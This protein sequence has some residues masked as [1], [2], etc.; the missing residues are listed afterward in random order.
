MY[1]DSSDWDSGFKKGFEI[2]QKIGFWEAKVQAISAELTDISTTLSEN[3]ELSEIVNQIED[4]NERLDN[5]T[6]NLTDL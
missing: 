6:E 3:D 5:V 1:H 2:G 4:C